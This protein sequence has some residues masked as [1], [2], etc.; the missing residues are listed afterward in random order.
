[1]L[2]TDSRYGGGFRAALSSS[3]PYSAVIRDYSTRL[4]LWLRLDLGVTSDYRLRLDVASL[5][6]T[7]HYL[8][9]RLAMRPF[10]H[11]PVATSPGVEPWIVAKY[12]GRIV[13]SLRGHSYHTSHLQEIKSSL[14]LT[15]HR[16]KLSQEISLTVITL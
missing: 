1:M 11:I 10:S 6:I 12:C 15:T 8:M 16:Q 14:T 4:A 13:N 3:L 9:T 7:H 5:I 2:D